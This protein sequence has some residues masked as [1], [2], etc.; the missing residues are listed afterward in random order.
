MKLFTKYNRI[1]VAS[2]VII[3]LLASI[4]FSFLLRYVIISGID[5]D[6][7][8]EKNEVLSYISK[9]NALPP[10]VEVHDQYT[11]YQLIKTLP[12]HSPKHNIYTR[13]TRDEKD[14]DEETVRSIVFF[15]TVIGNNYLVTVSKSLEGTDNLIQSIIIITIVTIILI[16]TTSYFINR[17]VLRKLWKP[18]YQSLDGL[19]NFT[20]SDAG[21]ITFADTN[22]DEFGLLNTTL[23]GVINKAQQDYYIL[24][25]FTENASHEMQT[26]LAVIN[27]KLDVI[28]Q[29]ESLTAQQSAAAEG[30]YDAI[31]KLKR[32]NQSLLLLAK[33]ENQQFA[34]TT[35]IN[36]C[37]AI[38]NKLTQFAEQWQESK[39]TVHTHLAKTI[40]RSNPQLIDI[41]LNNLLG[42]AARHNTGKG[43]INISLQARE[44][45]ISNS[46]E[47][48]A[49]DEQYVFSRFY[50]GTNSK[51][52]N[53]L[54]LSIVKQICEASGY[55]CRYRF[56]EPDVH[57][58]I[59][60][61]Q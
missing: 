47:T 19:N 28:I 51:E 31:K 46:G 33:I 35:D 2:T 52:G 1:N 44:L 30:A 57:S 37:E 61:W 21:S 8:I 40:I 25:E 17:F 26:P 43:F 23:S 41:L 56:T 36:L 9:Y 22:I 32:L 10:V 20:L 6:L 15:V 38:Q 54:G 45:E 5:E 34:D 7:R 18:F 27:S 29:S 3:F 24:K 58:F 55:T 11:T 13:H 60:G 49:L 16:L 48:A 14:G 39:L 53:G 50:K 59:I 42:N 12:K 4:A